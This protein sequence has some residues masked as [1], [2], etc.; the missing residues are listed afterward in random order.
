[1]VNPSKGEKMDNQSTN[2]FNT[3]Q[4]SNKEML[5]YF[6]KLFLENLEKIQDYKTRIF[7]IDI[8]IEELE[9]TRNIYAFKSSS[10]K[11]VFTPTISDDAENE[12]S[13]IIDNQISDLKSVRESLSFNITDLEY[14]LK[15][16]KS[17]LTL[18]ND[19][20]NSIKDM[21]TRIAP[22][23]I[24]GVSSDDDSGFEF[25]QEPDEGTHNHGYNILMLDAFDKSFY[26]TLIDRN[27]KNAIVNMNHKLDML[28]Y[29]LS[30]DMNR[31]KLTIQELSQG[32]KK[33]LDSV[34][35]IVSRLDYSLDSQ[36]PIWNLLDNFVM[37]QRDKHP[38]FIIDAD[39]QCTDY[40]INIHP[41]FTI[42]LIYL[43]NIFFDNIYRHSKGNS[44]VFRLCLSKNKVDVNLS[45][46]GIGISSD[47]LSQSPWYSSLHRAHEIIY[48]LEGDFNIGEN[49]EKGTIIKFSFPIKE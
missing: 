34:D 13:K 38:E 32:S 18:L 24:N 16:I 28:S 12:K 37:T 3:I 21:G 6:N 5:E 46:N 29:L 22:E 20:E 30:T 14:T 15:S 2:N 43:L 47:Y 10:R 11:S 27:L 33:L 23:L 7:E 42:N 17:K 19:A 26:S 1:M 4:K 48:L 49:P 25:L 44:I 40:E 41:V 8:K 39:I 45:D 9:K 31:A 36:Q 35:D